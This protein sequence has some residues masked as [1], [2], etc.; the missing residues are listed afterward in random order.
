MLPFNELVK[1]PEYWMETIQN[2]LYAAV[3]QYLEEQKKTQTNLAE[4]LK[5]SK[6]YVSQI[7]NGNFNYTLRKL[8]DLSLHIG[9]VPS[10]EFM[11]AD[12][13]VNIEN[14]KNV[15]FQITFK[16]FQVIK[17]AMYNTEN[18]TTSYSSEISLPA[19]IHEE[20]DSTTKIA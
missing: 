8:I 18:V 5:V 12:E 9:K 1:T 4:D 20:T 11:A 10:L 2:D 6:G 19:N 14:K 17:G 15:S 3:K 13:Y 16:P 7:M